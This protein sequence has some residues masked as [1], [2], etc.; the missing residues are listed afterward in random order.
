MTQEEI[1]QRVVN[2]YTAV[3][4]MDPDAWASNFAE[5]G[6]LEDPVGSPVISGGRQVLNQ[7]FTD[8]VKKML[9]KGG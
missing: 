2:Y 9:E 4:S 1:K 7:F 3:R 8:V 5:E 6:T